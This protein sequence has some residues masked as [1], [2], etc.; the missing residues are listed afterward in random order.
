MKI[1]KVD[2]SKVHANTKQV[3][4][5]TIPLV[6]LAMLAGFYVSENAG[7]QES[8]VY[9]IILTIIL[10]ILGGGAGIFIAIKRAN[11]GLQTFE[12]IIDENT[13][14]RKQHNTP[15]I[16]LSRKNIKQIIEAPNG[17]M[18][19]KTNHNYDNIIIPQNIMERDDLYMTLSNFSLITPAPNT[20]SVLDIALPVIG[21]ILFVMLF[22]SSNPIIIIASGVLVVLF[23][24][25]SLFM[26]QKSKIFDRQIKLFSLAGLILIGVAIVKVLFA[27]SLI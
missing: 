22:V 4:L 11:K 25:W 21:L 15:T 8:S 24:A 23:L 3:L 9:S 12:L 10:C 27:L 20:R 2:P 6:L 5:R 26:I 14:I 13:I 19:I 7:Q 17:A 18:V 1:Y 16:N